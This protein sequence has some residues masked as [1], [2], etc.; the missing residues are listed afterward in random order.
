M[1]LAIA[2]HRA[3]DLA[4]GEGIVDDDDLGDWDGVPKTHDNDDR[5]DSIVWTENGATVIVSAADGY[6]SYG[7]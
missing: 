2:R 4:N 7:R 5:R 6:A 1:S 3:I